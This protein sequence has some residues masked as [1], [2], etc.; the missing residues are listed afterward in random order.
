MRS[1]ITSLILWTL[2]SGASSYAQFMPV[3]AKTKE[4]EEIS[5]DGKVV[6]T[7]V[8]E[9]IYYR[10]SDGSVLEYWTSIDGSQDKAKLSM[11]GNTFF[12]NRDGS[13]YA[14]D[15][16][17]H[18]THVESTGRPTKQDIMRQSGDGKP[19]PEEWVSGI[20][21]ELSPLQMRITGGKLFPAGQICAAPDYGLLLKREMTYPSADGHTEHVVWTMQDVEIGKEPDSK[22]F[23]AV[24]SGRI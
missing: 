14:L 21:C 16:Y 22:L 19:R 3:V 23:D 5:K 12:D 2:I 15:L 8:R 20:K 11:G 9:G 6:E 7:H 10:S 17:N 1:I 24:R 18:K 13:L 4:V